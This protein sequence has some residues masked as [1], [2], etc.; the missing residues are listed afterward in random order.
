MAHLPPFLHHARWWDI[1]CGL[2]LLLPKRLIRAVWQV[3]TAWKVA[4]IEHEFTVLLAHHRLQSLREAIT[5][6]GTMSMERQILLMRS[7]RVDP[8]SLDLTTPC[9]LCGYRIPPAE[10]LR[11]GYHLVKCP[12]CQQTF[13]EMDGQEKDSA[14]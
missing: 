10:I 4:P 8:K 14:S 3:Y 6:G 1:P 13:D 2:I 11:V 7:R 12:R 9:P 5:A